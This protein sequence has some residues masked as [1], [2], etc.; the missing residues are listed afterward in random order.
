MVPGQR[1]CC[2]SPFGTQGK[3]Q[4]ARSSCKHSANKYEVQLYKTYSKIAP[5]RTLSIAVTG[6]TCAHLSSLV[7][8]L[9]LVKAMAPERTLGVV[10]RVLTLAV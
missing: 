10:S 5:S 9:L 7:S 3:C 6:A 2:I 1:R 8:M 4:P